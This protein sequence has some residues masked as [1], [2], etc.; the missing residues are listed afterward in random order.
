M[1]SSNTGAKMMLDHSVYTYNKL[2]LQNKNTYEAKL[3]AVVAQ[4]K[5]VNDILDEVRLKLEKTKENHRELKELYSM[6][7]EE[8]T[9][10]ITE[11]R[12]LQLQ[13]INKIKQDINNEECIKKN[14]IDESVIIMQKMKKMIDIKFDIN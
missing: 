14:L 10:R 6:Q 7:Y 12:I 1:Y 9:Q 3:N 2:T 5:T 11:K 8:K 4:M 13:Q